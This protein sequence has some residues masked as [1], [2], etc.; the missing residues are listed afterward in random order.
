MA[1]FKGLVTREFESFE[2]VTLELGEV[3]VILFGLLFKVRSFVKKL[4]DEIMSFV[5]V[6]NRR[7]YKV[8]TSEEI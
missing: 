4:I 7:V 5:A 8:F 2:L 1:N 6:C 3:D